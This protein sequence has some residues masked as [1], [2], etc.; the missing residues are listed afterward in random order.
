VSINTASIVQELSSWQLPPA[1][2]EAPA[3][4]AACP[5]A[6]VAV[7][8]HIADPRSPVSASSGAGSSLTAAA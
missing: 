7:P 8:G 2:A 5:L 1:I 6:C 4:A 3:V